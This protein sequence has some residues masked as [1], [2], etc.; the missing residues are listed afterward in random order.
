MHEVCL[1]HVMRQIERQEKRGV[2]WAQRP[3]FISRAHTQTIPN[4][5][6][7][8]CFDTYDDYAAVSIS[9]Q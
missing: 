6:K 8:T 5:N 2:H 9:L 4:E 7:S 1:Q 3:E